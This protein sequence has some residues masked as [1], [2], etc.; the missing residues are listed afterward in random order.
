M[1]SST[2]AD[3]RCG[4]I[5][6]D[7]ERFRRSS[8]SATCRTKRT[9]PSYMSHQRGRST[10][11]QGAS[12]YSTTPYPSVAHAQDEGASETDEEEPMLAKP[13]EVCRS[14]R[15]DDSKEVIAFLT[16]RLKGMQQLADKKI[17]KAWIRGICPKKQANFPYQN[18]RRQ[19][20]SGQKPTVPGW[21]PHPET[22]CRFTEPDHIKRDG[23]FFVLFISQL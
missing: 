20:Q 17:A 10:L 1:D 9:S 12:R 22:V 15:I 8:T 5:L 23:Q 7:D 18:N 3:F 19:A 11:P 6:A 16:S 2:P 4:T 14:F 21:W 13:K